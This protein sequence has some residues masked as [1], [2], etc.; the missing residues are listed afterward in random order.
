MKLS[1]L[2]LSS[3][4]NASVHVGS[5]SQL[6]ALS[7]TVSSLV[8]TKNRLKRA[9]SR[10][11]CFEPAAVRFC[12]L[13]LC[14]LLCFSSRLRVAV[15]ALLF[16]ELL[17]QGGEVGRVALQ[18]GGCAGGQH[19]QPADQLA[20]DHGHGRQFGIPDQAL[21]AQHRV[22]YAGACGETSNVKNRGCKVFNSAR[23]IEISSL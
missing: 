16:D 17:K 20:L 2:Q 23:I 14:G 12:F 8:Q 21:H 5:N 13:S 3:S 6:G 7:L 10:P 15:G 4:S 1:F 19:R 9:C 22:V 11:L 18:H